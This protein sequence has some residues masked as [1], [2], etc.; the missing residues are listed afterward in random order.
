MG[1][2]TPLYYFVCR[3]CFL[4]PQHFTRD[5]KTRKDK[6]N[7]HQGTAILEKEK[8][9]KEKKRP[10]IWPARER[11]GPKRLRNA[12]CNE[13]QRKDKERIMSKKTF[14]VTKVIASWIPEAV[15][16]LPRLD[17]VHHRH[18]MGAC[19]D[20]SCLSFFPHIFFFSFSVVLLVFQQ[21]KRRHSVVVHHSCPIIPSFHRRSP[22][23]QRILTPR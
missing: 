3:L 19:S 12:D 15:S 6:K 1:C 2:Q 20:R 4:S 10:N 7:R 23:G 8:E 18:A 13:G 14:R 11:D 21:I 16:R 9:K 17:R 22:H 5:M